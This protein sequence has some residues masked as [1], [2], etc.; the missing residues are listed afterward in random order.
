MPSTGSAKPPQSVLNMTTTKTYSESNTKT[1]TTDKMSIKTFA[2]KQHDAFH[3][4]L[5]Y[6]NRDD[7]RNLFFSNKQLQTTLSNHKTM[8]KFTNKYQALT[9]HFPQQNYDKKG[10]LIRKRHRTS[11]TKTFNANATKIKC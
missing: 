10:N 4:I 2:N 8:K 1:I 6:L 11:I 3:I 9:F 7:K 5:T